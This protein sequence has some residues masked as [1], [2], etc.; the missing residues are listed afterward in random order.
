VDITVY[1]PDDTATWAKEQGL[2]LSATLRAG[3]E[4]E[5]DREPGQARPLTAS[6]A[7][8]RKLARVAAA[9][10]ADAPEAEKQKV[11]N[12]LRYLPTSPS[13]PRWWP[14]GFPRPTAGDWPL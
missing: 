11:A 8:A 1:L 4:A 2:N 9:L 5:R 12:W 13:A 6:Q 7:A 10:F 3:V 14:D